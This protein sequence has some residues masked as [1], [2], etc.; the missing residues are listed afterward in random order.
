MKKILSIF[1]V[2]GGVA[3]VGIALCYTVF[4]MLFLIF[5]YE[6]YPLNRNWIV[7]AGCFCAVVAFHFLIGMALGHVSRYFEGHPVLFG[8]MGCVFGIIYMQGEELPWI[9]RLWATE[10]ADIREVLLIILILFY[11]WICPFF[12]MK[13]Y[14]KAGALHYLFL[15]GF[16]ILVSIMDVLFTG[17]EYE[18]MVWVIPIWL[19][20]AFL[21]GLLWHLL[22][23]VWSKRAKES[24]K[25]RICLGRVCTTVLSG[26][27]VFF[28]LVIVSGETGGQ[29]LSPAPCQDEE[30]YYLLCSREGFEWFIRRINT[31]SK[32]P[33]I[34]ARLTADIVLNDTSGWERWEEEPPENAYECM[35]YYRGHFDGDGHTLEGYYSAWEM[36]VFNILEEQALVTDLKIR[37]SLFRST[38]EKNHYENDDGEINVV[39]ASALCFKNDGRVE[40]CDVEAIVL[41]DWACGGIA[42]SNNG[43]M[44][45]CRFAGTVESGRWF[46]EDEGEE[47]WA[48]VNT[49]TGGICRSNS[50]LVQNCRNEGTILSGTITDTRHMH[51]N[52]GGIVGSIGEGGSVEN[53][54]NLGCVESPQICGGIAGISRGEI[55]GCSNGGEVHVKQEMLGY[56]TS[57]ISAGI[58]ASNGGMVD[59][60]FSMGEVSVDQ[61]SLSTC[62]PVYGIACNLDNTERGQ[63]KNCYYLPE[64]AVQDYRQR[65]VYKLSETQMAEVEKYIEAGAA[66]AQAGVSGK[67]T[68]EGRTGE[69]DTY[70]ISDVDSLELFSAFPDFPGTDRDDYIHLRMGPEQDMVYQVQNGDTLWGIAEKFYED[71]MYH[72]VLMKEGEATGETIHPGEEIVVPRLDRYLLCANEEEGFSWAYCE[73]ASGEM[74]PTR[75]FMAKPVDWYYGDMDFAGWRGLEV[76]WPKDEAEGYGAASG[77]IR[78]LYYL[79]GNEEGDFLADDWEGAKEKI[80]E[81]A[82]VYCGEG[83]EN[84]RFYRY[85]LDGGESLYGYSFRLYPGWCPFESELSRKAE[86]RGAAGRA[87]ALNC[88]VFYRMRE[89]FLAEFIGIEPVSG[90]MHVL[91]RT[92]YLAARIVDG[93]AIGEPEYTGEDFYGREDWAFT[94]LHNPF[95]TALEYSPE[96]ECDAYV[97]VK[98]TQ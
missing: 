45:D 83:I 23:A 95:A 35:V 66:T 24:G 42:S 7:L 63:T 20:C 2:L 27:I 46:A 43:V 31:K 77:D 91:E 21:A 88:A 36:P 12:L 68:E 22:S 28:F 49:N 58:C 73:D 81:S 76:L 16:S 39:P 56:M 25:R 92:R 78:I 19:T 87:E 67:S 85:E 6:D 8:E 53:C 98:G 9:S 82:K 33:D 70:V 79:D 30:G 52:C 41:G 80:R 17:S 37:K 62:A 57:V 1:S 40:D 93:P 10:Q 72:S 29:M 38:Y 50:G 84:L 18:M 54:E 48:V 64:K 15:L 59:S 71:G 4:S 5:G 75:Y 34:N 65:G 26:G 89:G 96:A 55:R 60:C 13:K 74:C 86:G 61:I 69:S 14:G 51:Y 44:E 32:E 11:L 90:D 3:E 47:R 94:R 97:L